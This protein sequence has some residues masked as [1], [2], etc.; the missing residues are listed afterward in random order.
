[1]QLHQHQHGNTE[2]TH[3]RSVFIESVAAGMVLDI[4]QDQKDRGQLIIWD[5]HNGANQQFIIIH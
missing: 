2:H 4:N 3:N 1:M 5:N